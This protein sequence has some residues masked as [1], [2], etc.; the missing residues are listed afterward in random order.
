ME[1]PSLQHAGTI[2]VNT[3][4]TFSDGFPN[5]ETVDNLIV[6]AHDFSSMFLSLTH[7]NTSAYIELVDHAW[8]PPPANF[9][10]ADVGHMPNFTLKNAPL[11]EN[12]F[13]STRAVV[14][15]RPQ[16]RLVLTRRQVLCF[17]ART[18]QGI[19]SFDELTLIDVPAYVPPS[20]SGDFVVEATTLVIKGR[21]PE[22]VD[23]ADR[24][25]APRRPAGVMSERTAVLRRH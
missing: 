2:E 14:P 16:A 19:P 25:R 1:W 17:L 20:G 18:A 10:F 5:L 23:P 21:G 6:R 15:L 13:L 3:D 9:L 12:N 24:T 4:A 22:E 7:I 11:H 8:P